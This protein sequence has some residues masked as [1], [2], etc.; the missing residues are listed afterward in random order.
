MKVKVRQ[1]PAKN[2][3]VI[4][5]DTRETLPIIFPR[6]EAI[7][8]VRRVKLHFGDYRALYPDGSQSF[9][10]FERKS[11][12]DL[13][14]T[15]TKGHGRFMAEMQ[16]ARKAKASLVLIVEAPFSRVLTGFERSRYPGTA[17]IK[18]LWTLFHSYGLPMVF[19]QSR[20]DMSNYIAWAF[21]GEGRHRNLLEKKCR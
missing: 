9:I 20:Q 17:M 14:G 6:D 19:C 8:K 2:K 16:R 13:W 12:A 11:V 1:K 7:A 15:M 5:Q 3:I 4:L 21:I 18:K 10:V